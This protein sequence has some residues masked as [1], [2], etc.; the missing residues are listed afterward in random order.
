[1]DTL[2]QD[3]RYALRRLAQSPGFTALVVVVLA[4]GIG[5]TATAFGVVDAVLLR[6]LAFPK[7]HELVRVFSTQGDNSQWTASPPD[8]RDWESQNRSFTH[9]AA[10]NSGSF[11]LT[12]DGPAEQIPGAQV[13]GDLFNVLGVRP[14]LGRTLS[15][16]DDDFGGPDVAM[17]SAA[18]WR[19]RFGGDSTVLG[20]QVRL[21]GG[22]YTVIGVMPAGFTYP[23]GAQLWLPLRFSPQDMATQRGAHYLD[24]VGRLR[25]GGDLSAAAED[26]HDLAAHLAQAYPRS[27]AKWG[28]TVTSLRDALV[29][30][31]RAPLLILLAAVGIVL[32][33]ACTN[34]AGLLMV[35]GIAREREV[36]IRTALGA[37]RG[38]LVR[39][40]FTEST[41][42]AVLGGVAGTLLALW[43]TALVARLTGVS[44][45]LLG[46]TRLDGAVLGFIGGVTLVT[47]LLFGLFPAWQTATQV[48]VASRLQAEGRGSTGARLRAR[49]TLVVAQ[50]ALA[51]LLLVG[52]GLLVKSFARLQRVDP[53]FDPHRVLTFGVS[54][55]SADYPRPAQ[56]A[57]F[58][59]QLLERLEALPGVR[60]AGAVFGLPLTG[61]GYSISVS[62]VDGR[63]LSQ[64]EQEAQSVQI[65]VVTPEYFATL[66]VPLRRGRSI[67]ATDRPGS[68]AVIVVN[69]TAASRL[70]PGQDPLGHHML[71]GTSLG[72]GGDRAGGEVVGVIGDLKER[73]LAR[74]ASP[75]IYLAH[76][77]FPTGFM[78]VAIRTTGDPLPL[79]EPAR[80]ALAATDPN[81]PWFR[82]RT[83][84]QLVAGSVAQPRFYMLLL[85]VFALVAVSLAGVGLYGVLAQTVAQRGRELG[86]RMA[87][88]ATARD[89]VR[90]VL[91]QSARLAA[92]GVVVGLLG[93]LAAARLLTSL[94]FG[95]QPR[96]P[97]TFAVVGF[98]LFGVALVATFV[99]ARRASRVDPMEALRTE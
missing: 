56:S 12:G 33:I 68:P 48:G 73:G 32:L 36:A 9:L 55:P 84:E 11:A 26:I 46:E 7:A 43:G 30:D 82:V 22:S 89:V 95:V 16:S 94:L 41:A 21:D 86:V 20:R 58:Y 42:L 23:D 37:G 1:M 25:P 83:M 54:L 29:G 75:T 28:A 85:A 45:P 97:A 31:V 78:S 24:V 96:D 47:V 61:F 5:G 17:L 76:A 79:T 62:S 77:Q 15:P 8:F 27:N 64:D 13:T 10:T 39:A 2:L 35:R 66:G 93:G 4:L 99:P 67:D 49:N 81:V 69:E 44:I 57:L 63:T 59:Q 91:R 52:A 87:L 6:P 80:A 65:R 50:T 60:S 53:G 70:W 38:R 3:I 72:L 19:R 51:A 74:A 14:M 92:A 88:G 34:V 90:L 18:L 98:G 40:L 71:V